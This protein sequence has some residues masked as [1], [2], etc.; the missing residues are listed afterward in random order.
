MRCLCHDALAFDASNMTVLCMNLEWAVSSDARQGVLV[1]SNGHVYLDSDGRERNLTAKEIYEAATNPGAAELELNRSPA[2][3]VP[4][5]VFMSRPLPVVIWVR[6]T[7]AEGGIAVDPAVELRGRVIAVSRSDEDHILI[8]N[9]WYPLDKASFEAAR[10]WLGR[11]VS[12]TNEAALVK[13]ANLYRGLDDAVQI[14]DEV[15]IETFRS[16]V[17]PVAAPAGLHAELYPYQMTGYNWLSASAEASLG[18]ILADEM[19]LGKTVQVIA[20]LE[21][22]CSRGDRPSLVIAPVTLIENWRRELKRFAPG[23][24]VYVHRGAHRAHYAGALSDVDVVLTSYETAVNDR[25]LMLMVD[26]DILVMDEAQNVRNPDTIRARQLRDLP[27]RA[28]IMMTGTPIEN[29]TMDLWS[30]ADF[31]V[32]GYMGS[33]EEFVATLSDRPDLLARASRPIILRREVVDV[34]T[35]LPERVDIDIPLEMFEPEAAGYDELIAGTRARAGQVPP[36]ALI[37]T[38]REYTAHP[39][40]LE[41]DIGTD[42]ILRS[43][44]L[45]QL[46]DMLAEIFASGQKVLV[47][48]AFRAMSDLIARVVRE[49]LN[50]PAWVMDGRTPPVRRQLVVDEF[51]QEGSPAALVLHPATGGAGLNITAAN[52][53]IHYTLEW[54]PAKESQATARVYR[55]G[56]LLPVFVYRFIYSGTIDDVIA[57]VLQRKQDLANQVIQSSES[58]ELDMVARALRERASYRSSE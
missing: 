20:L 40:L 11:H 1:A 6:G 44:K 31:A 37:T 41:G 57:D 49:R 15:D 2:E 33:Q 17:S 42:P 4:G 48:C 58:L 3:T 51:S 16:S 29:R 54:N 34:A 25:G 45:A 9:A 14:R 55:R 43:A 39:S 26:W 30:I 52:H 56:Q 50:A 27:R 53:V 28:T 21:E 35:D 19:G 24:R 12:P 36:L 38:L 18:C 13:Y 32:P 10:G 23:I 47:F 8:G 5:V 22:R 7:P 46:V